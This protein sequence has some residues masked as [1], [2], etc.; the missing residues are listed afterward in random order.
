MKQQSRPAI[1]ILIVTLNNERSL[2]R[3]LQAIQSQDYPKKQIELLNVDGGS[4]DATLPILK[5]F[6][7]RS[8]RSTVGANAEAQRGI[9]LAKAKHNLIVSL[10]ADNYLPH[11]KWLTMMVRP[12]MDDPTIVHAGTLHFHYKKTDALFNRYNA[13]YGAVDP[14]VFY[15]G[16]PDR[17]P[18]YI[19]VW[20]GGHVVKRT[21][22]YDVAEFTADTLPTVGC[23]GV[24]YRRDLLLAHASSDPAHFLHIDVF[25]DLIAKGY[26]RFA[27]V[28]TDVIHDTAISLTFLMK[29]RIA[30]LLGYYLKSSVKRRYMIYDPGKPADR[31]RLF[32]YIVSTITIIRPLLDGI[33]GFLYLPDIAWLLHP[34]VCWVYLYAYGVA[35]LKKFWRRLV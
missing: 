4:T 23:N 9:G 34:V 18:Q 10:D 28:R 16:R 6:G 2:Q 33:R 30:F 3:C 8:I 25:A 15:V 11:A 14:I 27:I 32:I 17:K 31:I 24:V 29:K 12:F 21:S 13:L 19:R 5:R 35:T 26:N 1:T 7:F 20:H 22:S